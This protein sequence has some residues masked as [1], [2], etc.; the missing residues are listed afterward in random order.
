ML[1]CPSSARFPRFS[2]GAGREKPK[3]SLREAFG[4]FWGSAGTSWEKFPGFCPAAYGVFLPGAASGRSM[5]C[6]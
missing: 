5:S 4:L 3:G 2:R 6:L 1:I